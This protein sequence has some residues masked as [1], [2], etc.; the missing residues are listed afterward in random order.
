MSKKN[1]L[2]IGFSCMGT[3]FSV[4]R[5]PDLMK[6]SN[7]MGQTRQS[8]SEIL[9]DASLTGDQMWHTY[10]HEMVHVILGSLGRQDLNQDEAFVDAVA[11]LM[12]QIHKT[13]IVD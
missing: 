8:E 6:L 4:I 1:P 5:M 9:V 13:S 12:Y 3:D 10:F 11:G 7:C 2:P